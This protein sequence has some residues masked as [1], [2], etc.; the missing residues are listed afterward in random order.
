MGERIVHHFNAVESTKVHNTH[1]LSM[2]WPA[3]LLNMGS[4]I[5][6]V[7]G[8][9]L[10]GWGPGGD[11]EGEKDMPH[12]NIIRGVLVGHCLRRRM[13]RRRRRRKT[14]RI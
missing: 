6:Q 1:V 3:L 11:S 4:V 2:D 5:L 7:G 8:R 13:G 14:K 10:I 12:S 9:A